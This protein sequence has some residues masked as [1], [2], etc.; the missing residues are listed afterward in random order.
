MG[1]YKLIFFKLTFYYF[2]IR[3]SCQGL[4]LNLFLLYEHDKPKNFIF[5]LQMQFNLIF[6]TYT[7][8]EHFIIDFNKRK[9]KQKK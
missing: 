6:F 3:F 4:T 5:F 8:M 1:N 9:I 7:Y 2:S